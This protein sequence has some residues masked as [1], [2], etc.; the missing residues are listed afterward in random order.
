MADPIIT[1]N[2]VVQFPLS[3]ERK[4]E[5]L[6]EAFDASLARLAESRAKLQKLTEEAQAAYERHAPKSPS[7]REV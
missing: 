3:K 2:N 5:L 4:I 6:R 7:E 1:R